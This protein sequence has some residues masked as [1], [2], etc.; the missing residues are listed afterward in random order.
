M[1]K[2]TVI[3]TK[4]CC[5]LH[6]PRAHT[7]T[8]VNTKMDPSKEYPKDPSPGPTTRMI[9]PTMITPTELSTAYGRKKLTFCIEKVSVLEINHD[10]ISCFV[11]GSVI[12]MGREIYWKLTNKNKKEVIEEKSYPGRNFFEI[13]R[14]FSKIAR[15]SDD[16]AVILLRTAEVPLS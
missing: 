2:R 11:H 10:I 1:I 15:N 12:Q 14:Y 9:T 3:K 16:T 13:R 8:G 6:L 7:E 5:G 4:L